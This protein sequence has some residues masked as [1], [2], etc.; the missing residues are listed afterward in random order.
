[1]NL[2]VIEFYPLQNKA[3]FLEGTLKIKIVIPGLNINCLG[4][5][6]QK[7]KNRWYIRLPSRKEMHH[8]TGK[9][10]SYPFF[11]FENSDIQ[12]AF[13]DQ[14]REKSQKFIEN[15]ISSGTL[16]KTNEEFVKPKPKVLPNKSIGRKPIEWKDP[17]KATFKRKVLK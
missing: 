7:K 13:F 16:L 10:I 5:Y 1:M 12:K 6:I 3:D 2:E 17:P 4:I 14:L 11:A 8:V 15:R 9:I